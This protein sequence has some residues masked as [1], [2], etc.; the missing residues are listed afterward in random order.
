MLL[1]TVNHLFLCLY[2]GYVTNNQMVS[3]AIDLVFSPGHRLT[4][5][6]ADGLGWSLW[7]PLASAVAS[8]G[9]HAGDEGRSL[10]L[11]G[12]SGGLRSWQ[13]REP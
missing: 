9:S 11:G 2:H 1:R 5:S 13:S 3:M 8:P 10:S 4:F 6:K 7:H 12:T